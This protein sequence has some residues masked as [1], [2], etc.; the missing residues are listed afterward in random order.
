MMS[1]LADVLDAK[2]CVSEQHSE[3]VW[4]H[5][6]E[7]LVKLARGR[8]GLDFEE[9]RWLLVAVRGGA[10]ARLGY[11]SFVEYAERIFGYGPRFALEKLRVAEALERLPELAQELQTGRL[12]F[13][14]VRELT[15]VAVPGTEHAWLA[16]ARGRTVREIERLVSGRR[17]GSSPNDPPVVEAKR[18]VIRFEVSGE[19]L[20]ALR[21]ALAG[22][23][24]AAGEPLDE[25]AALL[26]LARTALGGPRDVGRASYQVALTVCERCRRGQQLGKGELF[27]VGP[28]VVEMAACDGQFVGH[29][30]PATVADGTECGDEP[31]VGLRPPRATQ[32]VPPAIR[33]LVERRDHGRCQVPGCWHAVFVDVHHLD[34]RSDGGLN[35]PENLITLCS[36]HH[37]ANHAGTLF[38][39]GTPSGGLQFAHADGTRYGAWPSPVNAAVRATVCRALMQMGYREREAKRA[40]AR[41]PRE[42][43]PSVESVLR[44]ALGLLA[45]NDAPTGAPDHGR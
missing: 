45:T 1:R 24:R 10:P 16:A 34:R 29:V 44:A 30:I 40:V 15:R 19:T 41:V 6:H 18:Q 5:A 38:I 27:A 36:A 37:R 23:R 28:E 3:L 17:L 11:G 12:S 14:A 13:S 31:H 26:L 43:G 42:R 7:Q 9:A 22:I 4:M 21:D 33:R 35:D 32:P 25:D 2:G 20:A 39:S 8:A